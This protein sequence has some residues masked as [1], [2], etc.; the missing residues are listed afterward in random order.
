ME[1]LKLLAN[2]FWIWLVI[3]MVLFFLSLLLGTR[4]MKSIT[5]S[6]SDEEFLN[7]FLKGGD[8]VLLAGLAFIVFLAGLILKFVGV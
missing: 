5:D 6:S 8:L 3:A 4:R 7:A 2:T 1:Y